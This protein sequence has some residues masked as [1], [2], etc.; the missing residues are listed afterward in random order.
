MIYICGVDSV[1]VNKNTI[2]SNLNLIKSMKTKIFAI[3]LAITGM[4]ASANTLNLNSNIDKVV[5]QL[6]P[7][8]PIRIII[9][10]EW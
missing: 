5:E 8:P 6:P 9:I 2:V 7:P 1:Q 3:A 10:I 4:F